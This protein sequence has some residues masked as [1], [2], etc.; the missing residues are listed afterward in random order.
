M[1]QFSLESAPATIAE[2]AL[3][4]DPA[5][6]ADS[7]VRRSFV[8]RLLRQP[9]TVLAIA[10]LLL[11]LVFAVFA[12]AIAPYD[13]N[14]NDVPNRLA[15][16]SAEHWLGTDALG[17]DLLSRG[18]W[19]AR[20]A[21]LSAL[22]VIAIAMAIGIPI[23]LVVGYKGGWWERIVMRVIEIEQPIPTLM[24]AFAAVAIF[25]RSLHVAMGAVGIAFAMVYIRLTRAVTLAVRQRGYV[26]AA[27]TQGYPLGR[28]LFRH[29][30]PNISGPLL[31]QTTT[32]AGIAMLIEAALSFLGMGAPAGT[33]SWGGMLDDARNYQIRQLLISLVPGVMIT[34]TVLAFNLLGDGANE[35]L[36]AEAPTAK[37]AQRKLPARPQHA[38]DRDRRGDGEGDAVL[39]IRDLAIELP[40][41][42]GAKHK[43]V[44]GISFDVRRGEIFGLVG[45]S[46]SGKSMTASAVLGMIPGMG[47][48]SDGS[49]RLEGRELVGLASAEWNAIRGKDIG[50]VFQDPMAALSP[51]HTV[52]A[53]MTE[54]LRKHKGMS[55][56]E[57]LAR[58][59]ELLDLVGVPEAASR[60]GDYP[61]QFSGGMAQRAMIAAALACDPKLLIA[62][63]PTTAL[64]ATVQKQV[65]ELILRLRDK[66]GMS[67]L[68]IT[69]DLG[70]VA[71]ICDRVAVMQHG[72]LVELQPTAELFAK[73]RHPYTK[74]LIAAR[75]AVLGAGG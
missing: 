45:E 7:P 30:L 29:I 12:P 13:P 71:E 62:D 68:F 5:I 6:A 38:A 26:Q 39:S 63:E 17:R 53:Q 31:V 18:I 56:R 73:A 20:L 23:G 48:I 4:E 47:D 21:L 25:G 49:I 55:K 22:Q 3:G 16:I 28:I 64:D 69:H 46:G 24:L 65:L 11:M 27:E 54:G 75:K 2:E 60:L 67:V 33:A 41:D 57:A 15:G 42:D 61:H 36:G 51:V 14:A 66:L 10:W 8:K 37:R 43:V 72:K 19:G 34:A 35:A 9:A 59:A 70:V 52:G 50:I 74:E 1:S 58:A 40:S 44:D 32:V